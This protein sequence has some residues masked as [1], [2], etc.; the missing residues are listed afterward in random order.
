[1]SSWLDTLD[2][3]QQ[4][5]AALRDAGPVLDAVVGVLI[6]AFRAGRRVYIFGNGG[7]AADAQHIAAELLGR[8]KQDRRALAAV[9]L[10]TD[11]STL[12]AVGNDLGFEQV[13]A[14]QIEALV[15]PGD[16][17]WA[18]STSGESPNVL[19]ALAA[20]RRRQAITVGFTGQTGGK[21][22]EL[23]RHILRIPHVASDRIQEGHLL[24][25][26]YVC[27]RVEAAFVSR[28]DGA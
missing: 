7:S 25:Y 27:E 21:M 8:F 19:A 26:H 24:A 15:L 14:R 28:A 2:S 17:V 22:T 10:T 6:D 20:A 18:L 5:V 9:A 11:S 4:V 13:F 16:V 23:C 12:T 1:M 3:H